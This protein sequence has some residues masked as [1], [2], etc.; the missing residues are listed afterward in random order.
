MKDI[1][2]ISLGPEIW[3]K[4]FETVTYFTFWSEEYHIHINILTL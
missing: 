2:L 4:E 1:E 3:P